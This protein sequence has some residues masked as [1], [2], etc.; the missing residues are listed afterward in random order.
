MRPDVIERWVRRTG[1][2]GALLA[3]TAIYSGVYR[4][5]R[6]ARGEMVGGENALARAFAKGSVPLYLAAGALGFG[7]LYL[8]W[9]PI[10]G[11]LSA[12]IR[13]AALILG[14]LLYFPGLALMV[15]G[16]AAMGEMHNVSTSVAVQLYADHRL[17]TSGPFAWMRHPM[18]LGGILAELGALLLYR[19]WATLLMAANIP[20]LIRR[21]RIEEVALA[22]RFGEQWEEYQR[23]VPMWVPR[24][25][26]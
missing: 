3:F 8:L 23:Q 11:G 19:T 1:A 25:L 15:W 9:R 17:V 4:G 18:Y 14:S 5:L 6:H 2:A 21:A 16:R 20:V 12:P 13:L 7:S 24:I 26:R 10:R 22:A